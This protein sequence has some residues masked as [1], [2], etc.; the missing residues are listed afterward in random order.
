MRKTAVFILLFLV[1]SA[2]CMAVLLSLRAERPVDPDNG[3]VALVKDDDSWGEVAGTADEQDDTDTD[4]EMS[5]EVFVEEDSSGPPVPD[6]VVGSET[7]SNLQDTPAAQIDPDP[8]PSIPEK[9]QSI[10][11]VHQLDS[12]KHEDQEYSFDPLE[13]DGEAENSRQINQYLS[14][15]PPVNPYL[16]KTVM[17]FAPYWNLEST[18]PYLPMEHL[19]I[20]AYFSVACFPDGSLVT[21]CVNGYCGDKNGWDGWNSATLANLVSRAHQSGVKVVLTI[22]NFDKPS[23]ENL[24]TSPDA[25]NRLIAN[26]ISEISA[27]NADGVNI[28]FEYIGTASSGLRAAFA[29]FSDKVADAVHAARPG[30]HVSVDILGSSA[31]SPLL[32][33][34]T[35]LGQTSLDAIMV[36]AYDFYTTSYYNGKI[37]SPTSPLYGSQYWYTV[38]RAMDDMA[39]RT[40]ANKLIMGVPYYGLEFPVDGVLWP[41][42][43]A[44]VVG[45]GA[46]TTY[47]N[48][49][50]PVFDPWHNLSTIQWDNSDKLTWYRYRWPDASSGPQYWQG[51]YD[52]PLSLGAKYDFVLSRN[53]GG[54]GIWALGYDNG[55]S[56]LWSTLQSKFSQEP[57][58]VMFKNGVT[59]AQISSLNAKLGGEI[60]RTLAS[61]H[62]YLVRPLSKRSSDLI[63]D[64][65]GQ[66]IVK[67][68]GFVKSRELSELMSVSSLTEDPADSSGQSDGTEGGGVEDLQ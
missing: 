4:E 31:L 68:A 11:P 56:E 50:D 65:L 57:F 2:V 66:S 32:Y 38:A 47:A 42:K 26:I 25:Q 17:G 23:I 27:K 46:I 61:Q 36:M 12:K 20:I 40:P 41:L 3:P 30:S 15:T 51:Y 5:E 44:P 28:D 18:A 37:A 9:E 48:V 35:A 59:V 60:V 49:M 43:N 39:A 13:K 8:Q 34:V 58:L 6:P 55:R 22:K 24:I 29:A 10:L 52:D 16:N 33:D 14:Y 7:A 45:A 64:Y 1:G 21:T 63:Q 67:S 54:I 53:L 62:S 19:S